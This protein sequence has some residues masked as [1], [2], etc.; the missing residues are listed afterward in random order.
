VPDG[1]GATKGWLQAWARLS[2]V[3]AHRLVKAARLLRSLPKLAET[4]HTGDVSS[5]H[6]QQVVCGWPTRSAPWP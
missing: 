6:V 2:G 1:F 3:V 5:E 4:V